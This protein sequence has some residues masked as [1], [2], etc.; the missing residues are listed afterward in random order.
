MQWISH[1]LKRG[2]GMSKI[3][4]KIS[5]KHDIKQFAA[6]NLVVDEGYETDIVTSCII[7]YIPLS[8]I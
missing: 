3:R 5:V 2:R 6:Y 7:A 1:R 4:N 8:C